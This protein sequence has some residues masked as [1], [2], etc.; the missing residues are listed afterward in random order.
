V[1]K[2]QALGALDST[3]RAHLLYWGGQPQDPTALEAR[4]Q[5]A[6]WGRW[7]NQVFVPASP[8]SPGAKAELVKLLSDPE[9]SPTSVLYLFCQCSVGDGDTPILRFGSTNKPDDVVRQLELGFQPLADR[10]LVFANA[11]STAAA[12]PYM[13]NEL[14]ETFFRRQCRAFIGTETKVPIEFA[15]RFASI[16]FSFFYR[17]ADPAQAPMAAGEAVCQARLFLWNRLASIGGLFYT[18]LNQYE[19]FLAHKDE[20]AGLRG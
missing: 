20:V 4:R 3:Y 18:Y 16:F 9:Q 8:D 7:P 13:A 14:A 2:R 1:Y 17:E 15:G 6:A 10:P 5:A 11:C 12:D 19:L